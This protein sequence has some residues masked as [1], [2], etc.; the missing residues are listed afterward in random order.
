MC[1]GLWFVLGMKYIGE[2]LN[3]DF[4]IWESPIFLEATGIL[5]ELFSF[6]VAQVA[7]IVC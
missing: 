5:M 7:F 2:F 3:S 1:P 4:S 6:F